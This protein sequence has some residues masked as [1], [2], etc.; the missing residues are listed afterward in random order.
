MSWQLIFSWFY[1]CWKKISL[2]P[3]AQTGVLF[4]TSRW[5]KN[6]FVSAYKIVSWLVRR[7]ALKSLEVIIVESEEHSMSHGKIFARSCAMKRTTRFWCSK[8]KFASLLPF[9]CLNY[10]PIMNGNCKFSFFTHNQC[11]ACGTSPQEKLEN[12]LVSTHAQNRSGIEES[13]K[14]QNFFT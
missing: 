5:Y 4:I 14:L 2:L 6:S 8:W 7:I 1:F 13:A 12:L 10:T 11:E 9:S 3:P